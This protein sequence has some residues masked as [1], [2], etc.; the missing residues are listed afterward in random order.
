MKR[1]VL[2]F[3][4]FLTTTQFN[5]LAVKQRDTGGVKIL[6]RSE[7]FINRRRGDSLLH[8]PFRLFQKLFTFVERT[9]GGKE[10]ENKAP[11]P[12][13]IKRQAS[14]PIKKRKA[15]RRP[16]FVRTLSD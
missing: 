6:V 13:P 2:F 16:S 15:T 5:L 12:V 11:I 3:I 7:S 1:F 10:P 4:I 14:R 8:K 9:I